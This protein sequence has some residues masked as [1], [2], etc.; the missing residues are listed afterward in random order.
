MRF[1][2]FA[3]PFFFVFVDACHRGSM[4][5][6]KYREIISAGRKE[7]EADLGKHNEC[8]TLPE[9]QW[10]LCLR[11]G[12]PELFLPSVYSTID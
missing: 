11:M 6:I 2:S 8:N 5:S 12:R 1:V 9:S 10:Q 7:E 3:P 4:D